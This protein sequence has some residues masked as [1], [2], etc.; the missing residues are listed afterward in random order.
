MAID[1]WVGEAIR[2]AREEIEM[3]PCDLAAEA[4]LTPSQLSKIEHG[5]RRV[6]CEEAT[7]VADALGLPVGRFLGDR[8]TG[9][10]ESDLYRKTE[11]L[12]AADLQAAAYEE[13]LKGIPGWVRALCRALP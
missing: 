11:A 5:K 3:R 6:S 12:V 4:G 7:R 2:A 9:R 13:A 1:S 8:Y 10:L